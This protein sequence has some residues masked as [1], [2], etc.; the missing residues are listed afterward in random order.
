L[1][2]A[3]EHGV[4]TTIDV[5]HAAVKR[6]YKSGGRVSRLSETSPFLRF[7]GCSPRQSM[8]PR[9]ERGFVPRA[10]VDS[11][12]A[13]D[14]FLPRALGIFPRSTFPAGMCPPLAEAETTARL[15]TVHMALLSILAAAGQTPGRPQ[16]IAD[17]GCISALT[18]LRI[19]WQLQ[20]LLFTFGSV[21]NPRRLSGD[22]GTV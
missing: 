1:R 3:R 8:P 12:G 11:N 21:S 4:L 19:A 18:G 9:A 6:Q 15:G 7:R 13:S 14:L 5:V 20:G 2:R 10:G 17:V 16:G 22:P